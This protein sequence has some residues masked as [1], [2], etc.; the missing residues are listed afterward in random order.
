MDRLQTS[1]VTLQGFHLGTGV[2]TFADPVALFKGKLCAAA[3]RN[4]FH[5][6]ADLRMLLTRFEGRIKPK[7]GEL[8]LKYVGLAI[9]RYTILETIFKN[10]G[11]DVK[12]AKQLAGSPD[13]EQA[14][15]RG[16]GQI[17]SALLK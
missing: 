10:L 4:K 11:V 6:S 8:N 2:S 16:A 3:T 12:R 7:I 17:Q 15:P 9:K 5:D 14:Y 1:Q 13:A